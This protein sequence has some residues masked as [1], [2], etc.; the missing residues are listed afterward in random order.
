MKQKLQS[1]LFPD[2]NSKESIME[3]T[4]ANIKRTE[5]LIGICFKQVDDL[6]KEIS[7][8]IK[9][10]NVAEVKKLV[11][12]VKRYL[13][14]CSNCFDLLLHTKESTDYFLNGGIIG[15]LVRKYPSTFKRKWRN[16]KK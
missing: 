3:W 14:E 9:N 8:E 7:V 6:N 12:L 16:E 2:I 4:D 13:K 11:K 5:N 10:G 15:E 1:S